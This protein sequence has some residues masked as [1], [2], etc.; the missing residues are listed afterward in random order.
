M[1]LTAVLATLLAG[2]AAAQ[3]IPV[4]QDGRDARSEATDDYRI[5]AGDTLALKFFYVPELD[6]TVIVRP[7]GKVNLPLIGA[8]AAAEWT[9][10]QFAQRLRAAYAGELRDPDVSVEIEKGF[11][12][13]QVFIGGEVGQPG[14][15]SLTPGLTLLRALIVAQGMNDSAAPNRVLILRRDASGKPRVIETNVA[16]QMRGK[17]V[18]D[19]VL[20]PFD[21]V[22]V[23][24]SHISRVNRWVDQYVRKNLPISLSYDVSGEVGL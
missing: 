17:A 2:T 14:M 20:Q 18:V 8:I 19:P 21:V 23:P 13:Q 4:T 6:E 10:E 5:T 22:L 7:D 1:L 3:D 15:Q 9:P 12:R 24:P 16:R 11:A